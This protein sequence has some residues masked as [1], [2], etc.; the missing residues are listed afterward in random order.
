MNKYVFRIIGN[1]EAKQSFRFT[2]KGLRYKP[3][4]FAAKENDIKLQIKSQMPKGF[5]MIQSG[6]AIFYRFIFSYP[7]VIPK[8]KRAIERLFRNKKPD[9]DN[10]QKMVN[11]AIKGLVIRDDSQIVKWT[12]EKI[13]ADEP[14]VEIEVIEIPEDLCH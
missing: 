9:S 10:L 12:G 3:K 11:D 13:Y 1:P 14:C 7:Q 4:E 2:K 6:V 8:K 5:K